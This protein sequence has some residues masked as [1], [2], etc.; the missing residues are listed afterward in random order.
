MLAVP[1]VHVCTEHEYQD[2]D[3]ELPTGNAQH[4]ADGS[5]QQPSSEGN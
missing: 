2:G 1:A 3:Y 4:A 5:D